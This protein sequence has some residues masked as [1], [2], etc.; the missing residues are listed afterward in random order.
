MIPVPKVSD[1]GHNCKYPSETDC[2]MEGVKPVR[3]P[4]KVPPNAA[5]TCDAVSAAFH[6]L[7]SSTSPVKKFVAGVT[8]ELAP[9]LTGF[10]PV[11][12]GEAPDVDFVATCTPSMYSMTLAP[13]FVTTA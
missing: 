10:V 5:D 8:L 3:K 6:S 11:V 7:T 13:L 2:Q 12:S 1:L 9:T 4:L